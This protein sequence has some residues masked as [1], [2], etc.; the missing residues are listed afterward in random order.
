MKG[1]LCGVKRAGANVAVN[2]A[3]RRQRQCRSRIR[4]TRMRVHD[5]LLAAGISYG[6]LVVSSIVHCALRNV[7]VHP[8]RHGLAGHPD[9]PSLLACIERAIYRLQNTHGLPQHPLGDGSD[10]EAVLRHCADDQSACAACCVS[11]ARRSWNKSG[12]TRRI[13]CGARSQT[14]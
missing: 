8:R 13:G 12:R 4:Y 2:D 5:R 7:P 6:G 9:Q 11:F 14:H 10:P 1:L 3:Q